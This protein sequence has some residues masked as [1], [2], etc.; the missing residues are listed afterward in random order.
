MMLSS[1]NISIL[2]LKLIFCPCHAYMLFIEEID[3]DIPLHDLISIVMKTKKVIPIKEFIFILK[4]TY[5]F[6]F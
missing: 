1:I 5:T 4:V 6:Q 2:I 3:I